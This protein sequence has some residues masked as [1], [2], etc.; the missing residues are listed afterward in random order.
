MPDSGKSGASTPEKPGFVQ[1]LK[2]GA[3]SLA[4]G[5]NPLFW[6]M[7][8]ATEG[9]QQFHPDYLW[10]NS[11]PA[12]ELSSP[13]TYGLKGFS[14]QDLHL[15]TGE[16]VTAWYK[17]AK[18]NFPTIVYFHGNSAGLDA[19]TDFIN[20]FTRETLDKHKKA[21]GFGLIIAAYPGFK[22]H[23]PRPKVEP[24]EV[25]CI[26]TGHAMVRD[27]MMTK[28]VPVEDMLFFGESLG[29]AVALRVAHDLKFGKYATGPK[30]PQDYKDD[31]DAKTAENA[32]EPPE[33]VVAK[34]RHTLFS[35]VNELK[36]QNPA[37]SRIVPAVVCWGTFSSLI[38]K[39]RDM[40]P[41]QFPPLPAE[42]FIK[43][44]FESDQIISDVDNVMLLHGK[45]DE[46]TAYSHAVDL[47]RASQGNAQLELL[48]GCNHGLYTKANDSD[49]PDLVINNADQMQWMADRVQR[50][51]SSRW[52]IPDPSDRSPE[53]E[54]VQYE[55][56]MH[57]PMVQETVEPVTFMRGNGIFAKALSDLDKPR[58][59]GAVMTSVVV[60]PDN[61]LSISIGNSTN[62]A[63]TEYRK[64][65]ENL[66]KN[67]DIPL[68]AVQID[69]ALVHTSKDIT[70]SRINLT[71]PA[72]YGPNAAR[73]LQ[74]N[75]EIQAAI[76]TNQISTLPRLSDWGGR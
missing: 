55:D 66:L 29:G 45:E 76:G 26:E 61:T 22:G 27:L 67:A 56:A 57:M 21:Q 23:V 46:V 62:D 41:H 36:E 9:F 47:L 53:V 4:T 43:N 6:G 20:E 8:K 30:Y 73:A 69:E 2:D 12:P 75:S 49:Y 14:P 11:D 19:R 51:A 10:R 72:E 17:P 59:G 5:R 40:Y 32:T 48:P 18:G 60:H 3:I 38:Q 74:L 13:D 65:I 71:I 25:A 37:P 28:G 31:A 39:V 15:D 33:G 7:L 24:S 16:T 44:R 54:T 42:K 1:R 70:D 50:F 68:N 64:Q 58:H 52:D 63:L 35:E 34:V